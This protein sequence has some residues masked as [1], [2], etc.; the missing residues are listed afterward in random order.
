[1]KE[2]VTK[3]NGALVQGSTVGATSGR[4][5]PSH[6]S[7]HAADR[8]W[9]AS[10]P[11]GGKGAPDKKL[12]MHIMKMDE[13]QRRQLSQFEKLAA[14][15]VGEMAEFVVEGQTAKAMAEAI[16][17]TEFGKLRGVPSEDGTYVVISV[18]PKIVGE[19]ATHP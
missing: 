19:T 11:N 6:E 1:M 12:L 15:K 10:N 16:R 5:A 4:E 14:A 2:M 18:Q 8:H 13:E 17:N 9:V 7:A 3:E